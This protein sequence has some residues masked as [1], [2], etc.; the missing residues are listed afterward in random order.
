MSTSAPAVCSKQRAKAIGLQRQGK[1]GVDCRGRT[2]FAQILDQIS[3][4][5]RRTGAEFLGVP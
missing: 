3:L 5:P 1:Q 2:K 4:S